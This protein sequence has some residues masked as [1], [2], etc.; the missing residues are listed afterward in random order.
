VFYPVQR[1]RNATR[2]NPVRDKSI[3]LRIYEMMSRFSRKRKVGPVPSPVGGAANRHNNAIINLEA[4]RPP[5][6]DR[7]DVSTSRVVNVD[8][9]S[10]GIGHIRDQDQMD[11]T[12]NFKAGAMPSISEMGQHFVVAT[13]SSYVN[14]SSGYIPM[15]DRQM[16]PVGT[17]PTDP[18]VNSSSLI[19]SSEDV[20]GG[21]P[22]H[23][24]T[25]SAFS[26]R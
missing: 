9:E 13:D 26:K 1:Q 16:H 22:E 6:S 18:N 2:A 25:L 21:S 12:S 3:Q 14:N 17:D 15:F 20:V 7:P 24:L 23:D 4:C 5:P 19:R 11:D 8:M 10:G